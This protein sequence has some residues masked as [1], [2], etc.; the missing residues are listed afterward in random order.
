LRA[1]ALKAMLKYCL[2]TWRHRHVSMI[3]VSRSA[4]SGSDDSSDVNAAAA[5]KVR[6]E[7]TATFSL[8]L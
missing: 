8:T 1:R 7:E 5:A 2:S 6:G 4:S 3:Q